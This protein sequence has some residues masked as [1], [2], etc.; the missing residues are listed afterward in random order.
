[1]F[2]LP[3]V[4]GFPVR[5]D[6]KRYVVFAMIASFVLSRTLVPTMGNY[7]LR[8]HASQFTAQI[9]VTHDASADGRPRQAGMSSAADQKRFE[10]RFE[11]APG[12]YVELLAF[13]LARIAGGSY[14]ASSASC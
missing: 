12:Y 7:L 11:Q 13:A 8:D 2:F 5:A 3:G 10:H 4:A 1:M 14:P 9:M 6:G